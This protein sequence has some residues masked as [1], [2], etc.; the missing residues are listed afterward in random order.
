M[1]TSSVILAIGMAALLLGCG[2]FDGGQRAA[3]SES[4]ATPVV[5]EASPPAATPTSAANDEE[6]PPAVSV[7][8]PP[9]T[10]PPSTSTAPAA[11]ATLSVGYDGPSS[12]ES[13]TLASPV[14]ARVRLSSA[15]STV[16]S[17]TAFDGATKY[18]ALLEFSFN[19]QEYLKGSGANDIVAVWESRPVFDTRQEADAALPA[20]ASARDTQWDDHEAIV[21]LQLSQTYLTSTQEGGRF[22]LSWQHELD[23]FRRQ[24][25]SSQPA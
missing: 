10:S 21:F 7:V 6:K 25:Q 18:I 11:V 3:E 14:I 12:L 24:I 16:E 15:I 5:A 22:Y 20:I 17:A 8:S 9:A 2:L 19:V 23:I 4:G 1:R 13:R